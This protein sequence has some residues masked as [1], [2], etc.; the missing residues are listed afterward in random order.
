MPP[1]DIYTKVT[2]G[3]RKMP[4]WEHVFSNHE[5][6]AITAYMKSDIFSN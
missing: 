1:D 3:F 2:Y 5:R 4:P 6:A